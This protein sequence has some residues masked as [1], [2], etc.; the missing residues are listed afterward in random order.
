MFM[1]GLGRVLVPTQFL[2]AHMH[3]THVF[4]LF[5]NKSHTL[6]SI[7]HMN[8]SNNNTVTMYL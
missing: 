3:F 1:V 7:S 6:I 2:G 8:N 4:S 5:K